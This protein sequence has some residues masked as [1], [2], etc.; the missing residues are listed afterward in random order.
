M[1]RYYRFS[2]KDDA[3]NYYALQ[4][5]RT[6]VTQSSPYYLK[7]DPIGWEDTEISVGRNMV[8]F[9]LLRSYSAPY[10][11]VRDAAKILNNIFF[12]QGAEAVCKL[13]IERNRDFVYEPFFEC[14]LDFSTAISDMKLGFIQINLKESGIAA[15]LKANEDIE[16]EIP[17]LA[18]DKVDI[19]VPSFKLVG[20][21]KWI[22]S[23]PVPFTV[24]PDPVVIY[25]ILIDNKSI[26][27]PIT[28]NTDT[29]QTNARLFTTNQEIYNVNFKGSLAFFCDNTSNALNPSDITFD[30]QLRV[31]GVTYQLFPSFTI[32]HGGSSVSDN[33]TFD[34]NVPSMSSGSWVEFWCDIDGSSGTDF[35]IAWESGRPIE[36]KYEYYTTP[37]TVQ[38]IRYYRL[39]E[40][41]INKMTGGQGY[42]S[43]SFLTNAA[44][45]L[46]IG[47]GY[48]NRPYDTIVI[49]GDSIRNI[50]DAGYGGPVIKTTFKDAFKAGTIEWDL[51]LHVDGNAVVIKERIEYFKKD[52]IIADLGEVAE[53]N[54]AHLTDLYYNKIEIG[55]VNQYY[56]DLNGRDEFNTKQV[57][58]LPLARVYK[59][60]AKLD[61]ISPY[62]ADMYGIFYTWAQ[63][64]LLDTTDSPS[65]NDVFFI[66]IGSQLNGNGRFTPLRPT[67]PGIVGLLDPIHAF[68]FGLSP[69]R[70][71]LR[72]GSF[73]HSLTYNKENEY[74]RFQ[75]S[76]KNAKV[77]T[78]LYGPM[79]KENED[80]KIGNLKAR[81]FQPF[82]F[83]VETSTNQN[84]LDAMILMPDGCFKG[85]IKGIPFK[86]FPMKV[87]V[88]PQ[89][90]A[91]EELVLWA[92]PDTDISSFI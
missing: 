6:V 14:D 36:L 63:Y 66:E 5:L 21:A 88:K 62:R 4:G 7:K 3:G 57:Y 80:V 79:V 29:Y 74:I 11:F 77:A 15:M 49:C 43:S 28:V 33:F 25:D 23:F 41:L 32:N 85:T 17:I 78:T 56:D 1:Q 65:D 82:V 90:P 27:D 54:I 35:D 70:C 67:N 16:Y 86:G 38:G 22:S 48:D 30:F 83:T 87:N 69:K 10:K 46:A 24:L 19:D 9:G 75:T 92:T 40:L 52:N 34:I 60:N 76:D 55:Y 61:Y 58:S 8:Y 64:F 50:I 59:D 42:L 20:S 68:N 91:K 89:K 18:G 44:S 2:L 12:T 39:L 13:V 84:V 31:D 26:G 72:N 51:G 45:S 47:Y 53:L 81:Y 71:L 73:I 37:F